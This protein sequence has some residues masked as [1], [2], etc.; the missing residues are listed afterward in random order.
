MAL[1]KTSA[2]Y[3]TVHVWLCVCSEMWCHMSHVTARGMKCCVLC[4][5]CV[6]FHMM[7]KLSKVVWTIR[8]A[9]HCE[10]STYYTVLSHALNLFALDNLLQTDKEHL[11][12]LYNLYVES[13]WQWWMVIVAQVN[14]PAASKDAKHRPRCCCG[15]LRQRS[16]LWHAAMSVSYA[17]QVAG[18]CT[19][20]LLW[21]WTTGQV[22]TY[23]LL[24][25]ASLTVQSIQTC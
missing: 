7:L 5:H 10:R 12:L 11:T 25:L 2:Q 13:K 24:V 17:G 21:C 16:A 1:W 20:C 3:L 19:R 22:V 15:D 14:C 6:N 8:E 4:M 23:I 18:T 9:Q